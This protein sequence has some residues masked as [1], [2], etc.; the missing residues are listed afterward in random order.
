MMNIRNEASLALLAEARHDD[1]NFRETPP[2]RTRKVTFRISMIVSRPAQSFPELRVISLSTSEN[3]LI[4]DS[5]YPV[6]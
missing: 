6:Y 3:F 2:A 4:I 1:V 5:I